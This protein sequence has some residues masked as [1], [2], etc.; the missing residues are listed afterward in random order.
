MPSPHICPKC[1]DHR[2]LTSRTVRGA[3][4]T[5]TFEVCVPWRVASVDEVYDAPA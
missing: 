2:E 3:E 4:D 5:L 1:R